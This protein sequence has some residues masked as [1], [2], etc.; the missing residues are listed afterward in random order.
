MTLSHYPDPKDKTNTWVVLELK[1]LKKLK[2]TITLD[3]IKNEKSL[4]DMPLLKQSRLS[5][6]PITMNQYD[7]IVSFY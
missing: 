6:M 1:P 3:Q 2:K 4:S 7:V 5:V